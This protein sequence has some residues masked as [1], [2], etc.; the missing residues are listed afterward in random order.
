M[1]NGVMSH[2][3]SEDITNDIGGIGE[4][5]KEINRLEKEI[6]ANNWYVRGDLSAVGGMAETTLTGINRVIDTIFGFM[7]DLPCVISVFDTQARFIYMNRL[8]E[9]QGFEPKTA[10]G[11]TVYEIAPADDTAEIVKNIKTV[12]RTGKELNLQ[13]AFTSPSGESLIEEHI[14]YPIKNAKG[15]VVSI[16]VVNFDITSIVRMAEKVKKVSEFQEFEAGD[17]TEKLQEG[18]SQGILKFDFVPKSGDQDTAEAA[19]AYRKIGDTLGHAI[20]FIKGYVGEISQLLQEFS[21]ENFDVTIKQTYIGDFGTIKTS[22]EG[23][24]DSI[25]TLVSE[26][27]TA[28]YQVES[29]AELISRSTQELMASFEEQAAEMS[30]VRQAV[31]V[32]TEKTQK[33]A[34]DAQNANVLS[35]QVQGVAN[36]GSQH[37][38]DMSSVMEEIKLSS[39]EIAKVA[40]II[41]G[42]AFQTNLLAL[43]ASVE[44]ARAGEHGKGFAVVADEVRSLAGRSAVAARETSEMIAKSIGCVNEGVAKSTETSEALQKIV[45]VTAS[46]TDVISN[47]ASASNKQAEEISRI[48]NSMEAIYRGSS[49]NASAVQNN[50]SVSEELSSQANMLMS[51][52]D[53]FKIGKR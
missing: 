50:A 36:A 46:V 9:E 39:A 14:M 30:E 41:E 1:T 15:Q 21:N 38:R 18:L 42:I 19:A 44:A 24:I 4:L 45:E 2:S 23:L 47:I 17:I 48:Q 25:G 27:Q 10:V 26:I 8:C 32:L 49:A 5:D 16:V 35:E 13:A 52:V 12:V 34:S 7:Y 6:Q 31:H 43:N 37:M 20:T 22:M 53:R 51:L 28:T 40:S 11:K 29:G 33:N 3:D